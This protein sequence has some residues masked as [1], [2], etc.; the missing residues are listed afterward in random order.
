MT[1]KVINLDTASYSDS[2]REASAV[3]S[4]GGLVVFPTE[5]VYGVGACALLPGAVERLRVLKSRTDGKP[6]TVHIGQKSAVSRFVPDLGG[7]GRRLVSKAWPGPLTVIFEVPDPAGAPVIRDSSP[8][9]IGAM[10]SD[11]TIGIRCPDDHAAADLLALTP[12]PVVAASANLAAR[13]APVT[14][15]E[16]LDELDGRVDLVLDG[17]RCR[18]AKASTIVHVE[19]DGWRVVREG[20]VDERT[21]RKLN[22]TGFLLVC[23]GNTCRS[24]MAAGLFRRLLAE[25]L[26]CREDELDEKGYHVESAGTGASSGIPATP[27]AVQAMR[28]RGIDISGHRS[29]PLTFELVNRADY[30]FAMTGRQL[31]MI[32]AFAGNTGDGRVVKLA[33]EDIEDPIGGSAREYAECADQIEG[34]LRRRLEEVVL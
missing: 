21:L 6:F 32:R 15:E 19:K 29:Q 17:G 10:Y 5:T 3:L 14:A 18:Y 16:A 24:P 7:S 25:K 11:G 2:I 9:H 12:M 22:R 31:D 33:P 4:A 20:V 13:P 1:T 28:V 23:S 8:D 34:A 26:G 27:E 30:I